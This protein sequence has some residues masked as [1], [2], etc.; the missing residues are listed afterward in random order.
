VPRRLR[1]RLREELPGAERRVPLRPDRD[2]N[3]HSICVY[4]GVQSCG[5]HRG[6]RNHDACYDWCAERGHNEIGDRCHLWCDLGCICDYNTFRC[7]GWAL[8][9][10]PFDGQLKFYDESISQVIG[11]FPGTCPATAVLV[12]ARLRQYLDLKDPRAILDT[13]ARAP[14]SERL[15]LLTEPTVRMQ[16]LGAVG[17]ILW[18]LALA[19]LE[20]A[21]RRWSRRWTPRRSTSPAG[22]SGTSTGMSR[23]RRW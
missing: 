10:G 22:R 7:V 23:S 4:K 9:N 2:G 8:G 11:P 18:P 19:I 15:H 21:P 14:E 12:T 3:S 6:C 20:G 13:L 5:T 1:S 17:F 16:L